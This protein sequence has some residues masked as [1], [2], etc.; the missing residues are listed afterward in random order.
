MNQLFNREV[1]LQKSRGWF[2]DYSIPLKLFFISRF[3]LLLLVYLSLILIPMA[4]TSGQF[5]AHPDNRLI[6]GWARW[7]SGWYMGIAE[8]GYSNQII[9]AGQDTAFFPMYPILIRM[10]NEIIRD[11]S[12]SGILVSNF[13]FLLALIVLF[14]LLSNR[15]GSKITERTLTL[16]CFGAFSFFFSAVYTESVFLLAVVCAFYF[17]ERKKYL[18]AACWGAVASATR[19]LGITIIIPLVI[20]YLEQIDYDWRRIRPNILLFSVSLLGTILYMLFLVVNFGNTLQFVDSQELWGTFNPL[21]TITHTINSL[22]I[23]S[24]LIG[25]YPVMNVVHLL[26]LFASVS[27]TLAYFK[28][29][30]LPYTLFSIIGIATSIA[31]VHG[32]GRY[33]VVIFPLYVATAFFLKNKDLY[34]LFLYIN[35]LLL[36][37][38]SVLFSHWYWVA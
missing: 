25:T 32:T 29:I 20:L 12:I 9:S 27:L 26:V 28:K 15:Y 22:S 5:H 23:H 38:F 34:H 14:K 4:D 17:G 8:N 10:V 6:D 1:I 13:S 18:W 36:A 31:R 11:P 19:V 30:G 35:I 24:I 37:L 2:I 33:L 7:D 21:D 16:I 3:G